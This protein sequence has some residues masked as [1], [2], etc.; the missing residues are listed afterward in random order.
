MRLAALL[1][2]ILL[3][4]FLAPA[5]VKAAPAEQCPSLPDTSDRSQGWGPGIKY[6]ADLDGDGKPNLQIVMWGRSGETLKPQGLVIEG[7]VR[8]YETDMDIPEFSIGMV[9]KNY[10]TPLEV[11]RE[12]LKVNFELTVCGPNLKVTDAFVIQGD[13]K[14]TEE[15]VK[16]QFFTVDSSMGHL[17]AAW[18]K[19]VGATADQIPSLIPGVEV[20]FKS[21][22]QAHRYSVDL[23]LLRLLYFGPENLVQQSP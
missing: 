22:P 1:S 2:V 3:S 20:R 23:H 17:F 5:P 4:I 10:F 15:V 16:K 18:L 12:G 13:P 9:S 8:Y 14:K 11:S 6:S 19:K 7:V 21:D